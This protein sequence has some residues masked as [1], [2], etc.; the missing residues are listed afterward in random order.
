MLDNQAFQELVGMIKEGI[1]QDVKALRERL[2][3]AVLPNQERLA[4]KEYLQYWYDRWSDPE[5]RN[6]ALTRVGPVNF[7]ATANDLKK[8]LGQPPT[9]GEQVA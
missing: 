1:E 9:E 8:T 2:F 3:P 5:F 4:K 7:L 6:A